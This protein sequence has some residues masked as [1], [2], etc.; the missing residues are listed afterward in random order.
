MWGNWRQSDRRES[1]GRRWAIAI[2]ISLIIQIPV[3]MAIIYLIEHSVSDMEFQAVGVGPQ[4][5]MEDEDPGPSPAGTPLVDELEE[6]EEEE[7]L[8]DEI[9]GT[10]VPVGQIVSVAPLKEEEMPDRARFAARYAQK[11]DQ[12]VKARKPSDSQEMPRRYDKERRPHKAPPARRGDPDHRSSASKAVAEGAK[13][14]ETGT[15]PSPEGGALPAGSPAASD[16]VAFLNTPFEGL[17]PAAK[18]SPSAAPFASDDYLPHVKEE[19]DTNVLNTVPYRYVGFFER[20]KNRVRI[21]WDPNRPYRLRDPSGELYG[22][23][24][25]LT[26]LRVVLDADGN[27]ID[28]HIATKSGL[29]FLDEEAVRAFWAAGPFLN[30]PK[31]LVKEDGKIRFDFGFA[32]LVASSRHKFFWRWQ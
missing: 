12:E 7:E 26:V 1:S 32:F 2:L 24:D 17:D 19:G 10:E 11:T 15:I 23:K 16:G 5:Y 3:I 21:H 9:D 4:L 18:Y 14:F 8:P 20:V 22:H 29:R 13:T 25:R 28:T 31:G 6:E 30:P 27:V